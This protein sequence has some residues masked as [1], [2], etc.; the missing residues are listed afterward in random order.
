[1]KT[2]EILDI[3]E[4]YKVITLIVVGKRSEKISPV[5]SE[6]QVE[7]EKKRPERFP[8][9]KVAHFNRFKS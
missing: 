2:K 4:K 6:N 7:R 9:K 8:L 1:M 3:P 5:L